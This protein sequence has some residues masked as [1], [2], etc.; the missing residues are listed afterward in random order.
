M[1][2]VRYTYEHVFES[3]E[4]AKEVAKYFHAVLQGNPDYA[5][6]RILL[7]V[8]KSRVLLAEFEDS[9]THIH[10]DD[11]DPDNPVLELFVSPSERSE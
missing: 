9:D 1:I 11:S 2:M 3:A 10:V 7:N 8:E 6:I 4:K 5:D